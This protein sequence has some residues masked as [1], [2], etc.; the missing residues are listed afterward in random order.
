VTQP[1]STLDDE[2]IIS[3]CKDSLG[4]FKAPKAVEFVEALSKNAAGKILKRDL[5]G[6]METGHTMR[7]SRGKM[8]TMSKTIQYDFRAAR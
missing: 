3:F 4:S 2:Q 7:G 1:G 8:G 6:Q 5:H